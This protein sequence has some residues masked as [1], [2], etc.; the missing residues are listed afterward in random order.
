[1]NTVHV[2]FDIPTNLVFQ[3]GMDVDNAAGEARR[4]LALFLYEHKRLSLGKACELGNMS[5]WEFA[6][7]NT[8]LGIP[9]AYG[10]ED[11]ATD[12]N[13]LANT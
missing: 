13:R 5:Y 7:M 2:E 8:R 4:M 10:E 1:M 6:D 12:R 11:L 9:V 3:A